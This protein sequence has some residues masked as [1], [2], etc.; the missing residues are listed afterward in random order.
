MSLPRIG[1]SIRGRM[2]VGAQTEPPALRSGERRFAAHA[3]G[4]AEAHVRLIWV[5]WHWR[6][7]VGVGEA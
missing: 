2:V 4:S 6:G 7:L 3:D 5:R 1:R